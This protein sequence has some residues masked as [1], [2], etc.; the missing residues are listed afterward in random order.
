MT[1]V[2]VRTADGYILNACL[3]YFVASFKPSISVC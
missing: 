3:S 1:N 2:A